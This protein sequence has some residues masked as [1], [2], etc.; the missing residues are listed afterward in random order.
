MA[1]LIVRETAAQANREADVQ[2]LSKE[3]REL[4]D[5][6][7]RFYR[8]HGRY[9][10]PV[11]EPRLDVETLDLLKR[12]GYYEGRLLERIVDGRLDG[13][14]APS[15]RGD[16]QEFWMEFTPTTAPSSR[17]LVARSDDA[18]LGGGRW[19]DGVYMLRDG[20]LVKM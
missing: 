16:H 12:R 2:L 13:Y 18:P 8:T 17:F 7:Q 9:P 11:D 14:D 4:Y 6:M 19:H 20:M 3:A 5:A 10:D 1:G 15:D